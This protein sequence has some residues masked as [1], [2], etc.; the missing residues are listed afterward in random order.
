MHF[1][2]LYYI[3]YYST[4]NNKLDTTAAILVDGMSR[5]K[6]PPAKNFLPSSLPA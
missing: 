1:Y 4:V 3:G 6:V 2:K 5:K